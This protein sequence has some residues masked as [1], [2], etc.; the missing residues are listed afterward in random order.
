M[1]STK[2]KSPE[3]KIEEVRKLRCSVQI[4][5][6]DKMKKNAVLFSSPSGLLE[7]TIYPRVHKKAK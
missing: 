2:Q 1:K 3:G 7:T 6:G 5:S 4:C